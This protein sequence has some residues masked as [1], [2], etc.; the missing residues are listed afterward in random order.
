MKYRK[1]RNKI[2][3]IYLLFITYPN[4]IRQSLNN[5][6]YLSVKTVLKPNKK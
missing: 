6:F 3:N 4:F 1:P 5:R 2:T